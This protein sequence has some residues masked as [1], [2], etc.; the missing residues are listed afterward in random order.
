MLL[1]GT[2][3]GNLFAGLLTWFGAYVTKRVAFGLAAVTAYSGMTLALYVIFRGVLATLGGYSMG[4]PPIVSMVA[5]MAIP[6]AAPFCV[7][8]YMTVWSACTVY[9]WKVEALKFFRSV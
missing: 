5:G 1:L 4:L 2:L 9:A 3:L 6:P 8:A 7:S